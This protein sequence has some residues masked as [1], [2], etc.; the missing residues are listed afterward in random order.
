MAREGFRRL[1]QC[2]PANRVSANVAENPVHLP[3]SSCRHAG[4]RIPTQ[5]AFDAYT[6][7]CYNQLVIICLL[8]GTHDDAHE[9]CQEPH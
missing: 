9:D 2:A 5:T 4:S 3:V 6:I 7:A 1:A 8:K